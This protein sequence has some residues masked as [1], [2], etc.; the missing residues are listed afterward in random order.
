M[1]TLRLFIILCLLTSLAYGQEFTKKNVQLTDMKTKALADA[2]KKVFIKSFKIYYQM[3]AE[4][5]T[6]SQGGRQLGGNYV[7]DATA[8]MAVG[9]EGVDPDHLQNMTNELYNYY[10]DQLKSQ[11]FE[12]YTAENLQSTEYFQDWTKIDGPT[13]NEEQIQGSLMVI[14][15]GYSYFVK[16]ITKKGKEKT[17]A[18]MSGLTGDDGSFTSSIY[19]PNPK[20]SSDL[21]DMFVVEVSFNIPSIWLASNNKLGSAKIKGGPNLKM[22]QAK[23]SY[24]S[25]KAN[26]PGVAM[27][28]TAVEV[29]LTEAIPV[30]GVFKDEKF[31]SVATRAHTYVPS[32][33]SFF[34]VEDRSV[35]VTNTIECDPQVYQS[36]VKKPIQ[37]FMDKS[38]ELL[39]VGMSGEKIKF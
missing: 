16:K 34:T 4:A 27:P 20:L 25:G 14:P 23:I 39:Q 31:K 37:G 6:T 10:T 24:I 5:E 22:A 2:P 7:G 30:P 8:R 3:I 9:V 12:I 1:K 17:G 28:E 29:L 32:Y 36:E 33:A 13:I 35:E 38:L 18:F 11:G 26:K 19:G 15:E 21:E